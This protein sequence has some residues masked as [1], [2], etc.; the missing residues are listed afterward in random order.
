MFLG[1]VWVCCVRRERHLS[2]GHDDT[3]PDASNLYPQSTLA[4][5]DWPVKFENFSFSEIESIAGRGHFSVVRKGV[6]EDGRE[7]AVKE[8]KIFA[9]KSLVRELAV[10]KAITNISNTVKLIGVTGSETKPTV[11]YTYH[12]STKNGYSNMTLSDFRWWLRTLLLTLQ[13]IHS[14]GVM[15]R[16]IKL[17]NILTDFNARKLTLIDF[18]LSEFHQHAKKSPKVG[19]FRIKSPELAIQH[20]Y[21]DCETDIWSVGI[22]CLDLMIGMKQNWVAKTNDALL[23]LLQKAFG[24]EAWNRFAR[25]YND[26]YVVPFKSSGDIFGWAM[27]GSYQLVTNETVDLVMKMLT[28]DPRRRLTAKE[29]LEHPFFSHE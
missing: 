26:R 20:P 10:L 18:G 25:K 29:A 6:L 13:D 14:V 16:D 4:P 27:P 19:C 8:F 1:L 17:G 23:I 5:I 21:H 15:H 24:S 9:K 2:F 3:C 7:V 28:L 11:I 22:A 12:T